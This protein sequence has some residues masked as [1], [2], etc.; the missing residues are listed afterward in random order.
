MMTWDALLD[1]RRLGEPA[2]GVPDSSLRSDFQ[3][4]FDRIVFSSAFRKMQGKTQVFPLPESDF[5]HTRLTHS[6]EV[7]CVARSLGRI[8]SQKLPELRA[9]TDDVGALVAAAALAHDIGN[10][11]FGHSG[12]DAIADFFRGEEGFKYLANLDEA[13]RED[14]LRYE[15]NA[16][17]FRIIGRTKPTASRRPGGMGLT[18]ATLA[19]FAK[20][21]RAS[22]PRGD[23]LKVSEKKFGFFQSEAAT[24]EAVASA[25]GLQN[26][27]DHAWCR[28]PLAFL[29]EAADDI[30][31]RLIDLEDA[32]RLE[33][34]PIDAARRHLLSIL[35]LNNEF[36]NLERLGS[37]IDRYEQLA[38]L[39]AKAI[40][41]LIAQVVD[42]FVAN[43]DAILAGEFETPLL[44]LAPSNPELK[45]I[46]Q[47]MTEFV[48]PDRTVIA[49]EAAGFEVLGG[50]LAEFLAAAWNDGGTRRSAKVLALVSP[51]Y[52]EPRHDS[53][54]HY[55]VIMAFAEFVAAMTDTSAIDL[56]RILRGI[57]L[58]T[59]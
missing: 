19:A 49:I 11:P 39:R 41:S 55:A 58:P 50:L 7:S 17:G 38:Y 8:A 4:D 45:K 40:N 30:C 33:L 42:I 43:V 53:D 47:V 25:T 35:Q 26:K 52:L 54:D 5:A 6:M 31:Y 51:E 9:R 28:H 32:V 3:G 37:I 21:P 12:E 36:P 23:R 56:F 22:W 57:E 34:V 27:A 48:Y 44:D 2:R 20:Y 15:G 18:H 1:C 24:F 59:Y 14:L 13:Q 10:P 16:L 46:R 29:M